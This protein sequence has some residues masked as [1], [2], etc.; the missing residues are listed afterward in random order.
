MASMNP[1]V[2]FFPDGLP[3]T[4]PCRVLPSGEAL[5]AL[6]A[7]ASVFP[8]AAPARRLPPA[9]DVVPDLA[10]FARS[11]RRHWA[12]ALSLG[13]V[14]ASI[15]GG[16]AWK[17]LPKPRYTA[18]ALIEVKTQ[19]PILLMETVQ[20]RTD[21]R[22]FQ[23]TQLALV[24][25]RLVL[26]AALKRPGV[27][28]FH[29][30]TAQPNPGEWLEETLDAEFASGSELLKLGLAGGRPDELVEI[31][32]AV[33][34]AYLDEI[35]ARD[36]GERLAAS[37]QLKELLG[38]YN[39]KLTRR[40]ATLKTLAEAAGADDKQTL[41][42]KQ[43][44][45]AE[46][47]A[48]EKAELTRVRTES[49]RAES[50]LRVLRAAA[51]ENGPEPVEVWAV[52]E[53]VALDPAVE[54]LRAGEE[55]LNKKLDRARRLVRNESD[56]SVR[57]V[58]NEIAATRR[59]MNVRVEKIRPKIERRIRAA[60]DGKAGDRLV[61]L[62]TRTKILGEYE[63]TL[64]DGIGRLDRESSVFNRQTV[65]LQWM[66]DEI[67]RGEDASRR[68]GKEIEALNVELKAPHRVRV[69]ER[70]Q[71]A[72]IESGKKRL[73]ALAMTVLG[74][75]GATVLAVSWREYRLRKVDSPDEVADGL[76][77]RLLGTLPALPVPGESR[78]GNKRSLEDVRRQDLLIESVDA[79][80]TI[81]LR[82]CSAADLRTLMITSASKGEG[83]SSLSSHLA[84]SLARTGRRTLLVDLDLRS[85]SAHRLF[86]IAAGPGVSELL[87]EEVGL[88]DVIIPVMTDL[89]VIPAGAGDSHAVRA[90]GQD[91][92]AKLLATLRAHYDF[93]IIDAAPV[94]PV[95]DS[96][97]IS[98]HVDA[99]LLSVY[100]E[101]SRVPAVHAGYS[102]LERLGA[103]VLGVVVTG[104]P[105]E[106][107]AARGHGRSSASASGP[108]S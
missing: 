58:K 23:S 41:A 33:T 66:K 96:L 46:Q 94:L 104:V 55:A 51:G 14:C 39:E 54:R 29:T 102:R 10:S 37:C 36:R 25:S 43:Q 48:Q 79:A 11:L 34:D 62:T 76:G 87:R 17:T 1:N 13:T 42:M 65:D 85:P 95:A 71:N 64:K 99:V 59:A 7:A 97:V 61:E 108:G 92:L 15:A 74:V 19:K 80:R 107:H 75:F 73:A 9:M 63:V 35:V 91:I 24:K 45:A 89:D 103:R 2:P 86:D 28:D 31:V 52:D 6:R 72:R 53:E 98:Q 38:Q 82:E 100:R 22:I 8:V 26:A 70:A 4:E 78:R 106:C 57:E 3:A 20:E 44:L 60:I 32:N 93:V 84:I 67:A 5:P 40:R 21:F 47:V 77:L 30:I 101:V 27:A 81:L 105:M 18:T 50:E 56:P 83:K 68:I 90:L 49:K 69:I 16:V 12:L 88:D